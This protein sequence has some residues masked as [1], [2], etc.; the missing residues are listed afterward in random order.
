MVEVGNWRNDKKEG[1][2]ELASWELALKHCHLAFLLGTGHIHV[3][4]AT[5]LNFKVSCCIWDLKKG[6]CPSEMFFCNVSLGSHVFTWA[7]PHLSLTLLQ[8]QK[9]PA[10]RTLTENSV[11]AKWM[12]EHWDELY[13]LRYFNQYY[14]AKLDTKNIWI[15][16]IEWFKTLTVAVLPLHSLVQCGIEQVI[17]SIPFAKNNYFGFRPLLLL[18]III[19]RYFFLFW[20]S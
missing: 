4:W 16:I 14:W 15:D 6:L 18:F 8:L 12:T 17:I 9:A 19:C 2:T 10:V 13:H 5:V 7:L 3:N 20:K 11:L 1:W